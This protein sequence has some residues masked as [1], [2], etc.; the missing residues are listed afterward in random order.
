VRKPTVAV[1]REGEGGVRTYEYRRWVWIWVVSLGPF[2][3]TNY[4][5]AGYRP[6]SILKLGRV[7][8]R[9]MK[10]H[11]AFSNTYQHIN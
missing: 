8:G 3:F 10:H 4:I 2:A 5:I 11:I 1:S 9:E 6:E 7:E